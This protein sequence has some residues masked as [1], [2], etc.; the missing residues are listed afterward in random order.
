MVRGSPCCV[1]A[2]RKN[3]L[4]AVLSRVRLRCEVTVRP[5]I[6]ST[7]QIHPGTTDLYTT[8]M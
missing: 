7:V 4:A 6:D 2:L 5:S 1:R 3:A 8:F